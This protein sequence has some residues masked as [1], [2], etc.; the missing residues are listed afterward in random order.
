M[1][2]AGEGCGAIGIVKGKDVRYQNSE[3]RCQIMPSDI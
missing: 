2:R 3:F 1:G